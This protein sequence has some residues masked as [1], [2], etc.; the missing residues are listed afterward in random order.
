MTIRLL[1][2]G[3]GSLR[4]QILDQLV[5]QSRGR[6][7]LACHFGDRDGDFHAAC[8]QRMEVRRGRKGHLMEA[9]QSRGANIPLLASPDFQWMLEQGIEQ[10]HRAGPNYRYRSHN[11][12]HVQD[13]LDYYHILADA[14]A[15]QIEETGATHAL[16][17]NMPHL[18]YDVILYHVARTLG[19]KTL[20]CSQ[21]FFADSFFSMERFE[22]FGFMSADGID[23]PAVP[24]ERGSAPDLFYMDDRWQ[25]SGPRGKLRIRAV[26]Q[27]LR[28]LA[29]HKPTK[30]FHPGY[31]LANLKRMADIYGELPDWRDPFSQF[32]HTNELAYFE[33]LAQHET[34]PVNLNVP[35]VYIPL[36]NQ[37]EMST[38]TLGGKFRDQLLVVEAIGRALPEGWRIYVKENPRQN[39]YA[40]GP[41]FFHR[42]SRIRGVQYV[43]S[44]TSTHE[45]SSRAKLTA[46]VCST[47]GYE[48]L[49][50]GKPALVF[51]NPWYGDFPGV[52]RWH[53]GIDLER[54]SEATFPHSELETAMGRLQG[55]CHPGIIE[56]LYKDR[57]ENFDAERNAAQVAAT[58][59]ALLDGTQ[60]LTFR[61]RDTSV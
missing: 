54:I 18:G 49:R 52:F 15:Q 32:F 35:F 37:P 4:R 26:A 58:I 61:P 10:L 38:Q 7:E 14:Y 46:T 48:A 34:A 55:R 5:A 21:T 33:H 6:I 53:D 28:H 40:R 23:A 19:L 42:L 30:L 50:K 25:K 36:H 43:P 44:D 16:F 39:G 27:F 29:L 2:D 24:I 17:M 13:Y 59:A 45:L 57:A 51:G 31:I 12:T 20:V 9:H 3:R 56:L 60:P 22:D 41:M 47:A 8:L 11:L 1:V